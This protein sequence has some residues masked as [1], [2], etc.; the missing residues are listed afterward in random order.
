MAAVLA[1]GVVALGA[2]SGPS[3]ATA[4]AFFLN[5]ATRSANG[6]EDAVEPAKSNVRIYGLSPASG[7]PGTVVS[8]EG[9]GFTGD[10]AIHFG[11][12][13]VAHVGINS[14]IG[15]VCT[16]NPSCRGGI[17]QMLA[18]TVPDA[19]PGPAPVWVENENGRSPAVRFKV[20][21]AR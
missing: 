11:D 20:T 8:L 5:A 4:L 16:V 3:S 12:R 17:H 7:P 14:A 15:I 10:N 21:S 9:F 1:G 13:V 6:P 19:R 18:F 2:A